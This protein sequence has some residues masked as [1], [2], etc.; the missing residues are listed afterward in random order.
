MGKMY[1]KIKNKSI[2]SEFQ[3][4]PTAISFVAIR[5]LKD[6]KPEYV[7]ATV[8][9]FGQ[10]KNKK[11]HLLNHICLSRWG[12]NPPVEAIA[13]YLTLTKS[14][15]MFHKMHD[16]PGWVINFYEYDEEFSKLEGKPA[17]SCRAIM[18]VAS[19]DSLIDYAKGLAESLKDDDYS[20]KEYN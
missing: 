14:Y 8:D 10:T 3:S 11:D 18:A 2:K 5:H 19:A 7:H 17:C 20:I 12:H 15:S 16:N 13:E 6:G 9:L 4:K 1:D